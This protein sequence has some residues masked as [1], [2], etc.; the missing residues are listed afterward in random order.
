MEP[1]TAIPDSPQRDLLRSNVR[2]TIFGGEAGGAKSFGLV[3]DPLYQIHKEGYNAILFRRTYKQ[4]MGGDGLIEL[5]HKVYPRLGGA[6]TKSEYLWRFDNCPGTIRFAHLEH[7]SDIEMR[8]E[9]HQYAYIGWDELQTFPERMYLYMFSRNRSSNPDVTSYTRATC[10]PGGIGHAWVKKRF[11]DTNIRNT[12]KYFRRINNADIEVDATDKKAIARTFI[13][14]RLEDNPYL[15]LDGKG[16]YEVGLHQLDEVDYRRKRGDWEVRREGRVYHGF[17][18]KNIAQAS[19]ELDLSKAT[20]YHAHDFGGVNRCWALF[21]KISGIY[22]LVYEQ[23]L[24][25]GTTSQR[26]VLIKNQFRNR[27]VISGWGGSPSEIQ[28]RKD[29]CEAGVSVRQPPSTGVEGQINSTN[30]MF[31]ESELMICSDMGL[32]LDS[33]EN[34]VRDKNGGIENKAS[35][36]MLD[37]IR[38]FASGIRGGGILVASA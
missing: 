26:A 8:Y 3:L 22:Y 16:Q 18:D 14:A 31:V 12:V 25:E 1:I 24:P 36:H 32:A 19:Y 5:S 23:I 21:A 34:C 13:P 20:F 38:Y 15:W 35:W 33:L 29:Y 11:I 7:E 9:G 17:S 30:E 4:L 6:Y 28:P 37:T 10:M 2:E 27:K